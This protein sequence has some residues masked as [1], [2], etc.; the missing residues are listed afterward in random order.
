M[1]Y[2]SCPAAFF[3]CDAVRSTCS[4]ILTP[5]LITLPVERPRAE[6]PTQII[7]RFP[8]S[9]KDYHLQDTR[10]EDVDASSHSQQYAV[11]RMLSFNRGCFM[12]LVSPFHSVTCPFCLEQ[13]SLGA[14][15][16]VSRVSGDVL[17]PAPH[18]PAALAS[19]IYV[20]TLTGP[21]YASANAAWRCT[22]PTCRQLLPQ[23]IADLETI[24]IGVI[25]S[26]DAGKTTFIAALLES[27]RQAEVQDDLE[28]GEFF[29]VNDDVRMRYR[30]LYHDPLFARGE[31]VPKTAPAST[32]NPNAPLV[33]TL[34]LRPGAGRPTRM[35][36]LV[37]YDAAGD[38]LEADRARSL[39]ARYIP[40]AHGLIFLVDPRSLAGY[41]QS[42]P[43]MPA[44]AVAGE[45]ATYLIQRVVH[46]T[47]AAHHG[48]D[49]LATP[50][51]VLLAKADLVISMMG[52]LQMCID[53]SATQPSVG[54]P[55]LG[56]LQQ[57][58]AET[59]ELLARLGA[60][61]LINFAELR[62]AQPA[63]FTTSATGAEYDP[64]TGLFPSITPRRCLDPL[65]WLLWKLH[66]LDL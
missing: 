40:K 24:F 45:D 55:D 52:G 51:A 17:H 43:G 62:L 16:I 6:K 48:A 1:L 56:A 29:E 49:R 18:G 26:V 61:P 60:R 38:D 41:T 15:E 42:A 53:F 59:R 21:R 27:L 46:D 11:R 44:D 12:P 28:V 50:T 2:S 14:C 57:A 66:I 23:R 35:I 22:N 4:Q 34:G 31:V 20:R 5:F 65:V 58:D 39:Y 7:H 63:F 37:L 33:Y 13:I 30:D 8:P 25:G 32:T 47:L 54:A 19:R 36:N 10:W 9:F 3:Q 64:S